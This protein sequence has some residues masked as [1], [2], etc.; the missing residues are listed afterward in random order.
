MKKTERAFS[1]AELLISLLVTSMILAAT[2]PT[3]TRISASI[4]ENP[5][6][7]AQGSGNDIYAATGDNQSILV[8]T[9]GGG[10]S[11]NESVGKLN[12]VTATDSTDNALSFFNKDGDYLSGVF[13][14]NKSNL[15][16]G[17]NVVKNDINDD[18]A[19]NNLIINLEDS[20]E[21]SKVIENNVILGIDV[22]SELE[23]DPSVRSNVAIGNSALVM[24]KKENIA[25]LNFWNTIIG[26]HAGGNL[27]GGL[28][29][30]AIGRYSLYSYDTD[31]THP[32]IQ[33]Y[34][35]T[36]EANRSAHNIAIGYSAG[37]KISGGGH[38]NIAMGPM[39]LA[40]TTNGNNNIALGNYSMYN[41]QS[42]DYNIGIG[43]SSLYNFRGTG[44]TAVGS[45]AMR[46]QSETN[47]GTTTYAT[48][49]YN[50]ALG[51]MAL[52]STTSGGYNVGLG[53]S[54]MYYNTTG[55]YNTAVGR[56]ALYGDSTNKYS[57]NYNTAI[58][59]RT[60]YSATTGGYNIAIGPNSMYY[61]TT[62]QYNTAI[63][64]E[65][66]RGDSTNKHTGEYNT[67]LGYRTLYSNVDGDRN[68]AIG[69]RAQYNYT[70]G[71][72][73]TSVGYYSMYGSKTNSELTSTN[74]TAVGSYSL[75]AIKSGS[76][77]TSIGYESLRLN[78][79]GSNN[80][81]I[82]IKTLRSNT[83]TS[84]NTA[85]GSETLRA[86]TGSN[87]TAIGVNA[88]RGEESANGTYTGTTG[89]YNIAIGPNAMLNSKSGNYNIAI[90]YNSLSSLYYP[91]SSLMASDNIALGRNS[92]KSNVKGRSN[93]GI[94][95]STLENTIGEN[96]VAI[97]SA[98]GKGI[99]DSD[100]NVAL[101]Y[102]A[103]YQ[104]DA[105]ENTAIGSRSLYKNKTG[106]YNTA[107]GSQALYN[108]T[109]GNN[110]IAIGQGAGKGIQTAS[111]TICI[112]NVNQVDNCENENYSFQ[113]GIKSDGFRYLYGSMGNSPNLHLDGD[114]YANNIAYSS[115]L[116]LK[117][118]TGDNHAGLEEIN[119]LKVKNFT[120]KDDEKKKPHVGVIAQELQK[121]FPNSVFKDDKGY[122]SISQN[123]IFWAMVN[124]I[125][126][127]CAKILGLD[128]RITALEEE[129]ARLKQQIE[130]QNLEFE[131]RLSKLEKNAD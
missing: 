7:Y 93:I 57:G 123:E 106:G 28:Y 14:N 92:L 5:W 114:F 97:G 43:I 11:D 25:N 35:K 18:K 54:A 44:N 48:G 130:K 91:S 67:V 71:T 72:D 121:I 6:K 37:S 84:G 128:K 79:T 49:A 103:L 117:N 21:S 68:T 50:T 33:T 86:A 36:N 101:G 19:K 38:Y 59:Y 52:Y 58:G 22:L 110:N 3:I 108:L 2:V 1:L 87:N 122:L 105:E 90:G 102:V 111:H 131:K 66:M 74:N 95:H 88:L 126:E 64:P 116:R 82:G 41:N 83:T 69:A 112:V 98:A 100:Y 109:E 20:G 94:G 46:G 17:V 85:I 23:D 24:P 32:G 47:N 124:S 76:D 10:I 77:N 55:Q 118:I 127:L 27:N 70:G 39:A 56:S 75:S 73:N 34:N 51:Y 125:K 115:D 31:K 65:S 53:A 13:A 9:S 40:Y 99:S 61:N 78:T 8:G 113:I 107:I 129:N 63:G 119:K 120:Y 12:I 89:D 80:T 29:N 16:L 60:L 42:N 30:V 62:G 104:A 96:N 45:Y 15:V 4:N 26:D 81:A